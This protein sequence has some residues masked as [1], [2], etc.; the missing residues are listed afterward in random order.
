MIRCLHA[1]TLAI[2]AMPFGSTLAVA[3]DVSVTRSI[4]EDRPYTLVY[5]STMQASGGGADPLTINHP[6]APLQCT[7]EVIPAEDSDWSPESALARLD[8]E[9]L[10]AQWAE[11]FPGFEI[12]SSGITSYESGRALIYEG[13]S[14]T[15]PMNMPISLVHTETVSSG[16]GYILDCFFATSVTANARPIVN[17]IV[18]NFSTRSDGDCCVGVARLD[19]DIPFSE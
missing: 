7:L 2:L 4:L 18:A 13:T 5:P 14:E 17:F 19:P 1:L 8:Q 9:S 6:Q 12:D 15:S 10:T 16:R 3:S 11:T